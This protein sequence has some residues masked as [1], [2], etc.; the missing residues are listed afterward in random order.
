M[1]LAVK[2]ERRAAAPPSPP[3]VLSQSLW[4]VRKDTDVCVYPRGC[5]L[6]GLMEDLGIRNLAEEKVSSGLPAAL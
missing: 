6:I 2:V 1:P 3:P 5:D 4:G